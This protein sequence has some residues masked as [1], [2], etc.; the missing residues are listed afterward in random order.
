MLLM[1][2]LAKRASEQDP[3]S[4]AQGTAMKEGL[5]GGKLRVLPRT[6]REEAR[7]ICCTLAL[8]SVVSVL[9]CA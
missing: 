7:F 1:L 9:M 4:L 6:Y 3:R 2:S 8:I 5:L